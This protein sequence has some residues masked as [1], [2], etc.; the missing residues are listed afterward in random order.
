MM[1]E[2]G[3]TTPTWD[4]GGVDMIDGRWLPIRQFIFTKQRLIEFS[5]LLVQQSNDYTVLEDA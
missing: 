2:A 1:V 5:K 4:F 3:N